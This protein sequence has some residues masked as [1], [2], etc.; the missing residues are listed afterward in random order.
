MKQ[1]SVSPGPRLAALGIDLVI[2]VVGIAYLSSR[3]GVISGWLLNNAVSGSGMTGLIAMAV[4][5]FFGRL[6]G[7]VVLFPLYGLIELFAGGSIGKMIVGLEVRR[8][9]GTSAAF[10]QQLGRYCLKNSSFVIPAAGIVLTVV[11]GLEMFLLAA[12]LLWVVVPVIVGIGYLKIFGSSQ[13]SIHDSWS[14]TAVFATAQR[15]WP[16]T[17]QYSVGCFLLFL[18][19]HA[20]AT[21]MLQ[22]TANLAKHEFTG[23][24]KGSGLATTKSGK[25][26]QF[27]KSIRGAVDPACALKGLPK[28]FE[29]H[30]IKVYS[31]SKR[32]DYQLG[33]SGNET[34]EEMVVVGPTKK[35][36]VLVL[37][38][39]D[40]VMWVVGVTPGAKLAGVIA[41][42]SDQQGIT[43]VGPNIPQAV[44]SGEKKNQCEGMT[45][46]SS[47]KVYEP[48]HTSYIVKLL[49]RGPDHFYGKKRT[50]V[51]EIGT[52]S[53]EPKYSADTRA[54][55]IRDPNLLPT[56]GKGVERLVQQGFLK[57]ADKQDLQRW[58]Q[59]AA[60]TYEAKDLDSL[61]QRLSS[62][63]S[64]NSV[65]KM[66]KQTNL[67]SG[68][69][70]AHSIV[71]IVPAGMT[72]PAE[73]GHSTF[74][75]QS[76]FTC[77]DAWK[78]CHM[79]LK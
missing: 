71:L 57:V 6:F 70:G 31:G 17:I 22:R 52:V 73:R 19:V 29:V 25:S 68:L 49:G 58:K 43:G 32:V 67:P 23:V 26:K 16:R 51:F 72:I 34:G 46:V 4:G 38:G 27:A 77:Q 56:G 63:M 66:V 1:T 61:V 33:E 79:E 15:S 60:R 39:G 36:V 10:P 53:G 42:G 14:R 18:A 7:F 20:A 50:D 75:V 9:D 65:Y 28:D 13:S 11:T 78:H 40:P 55:Y 44:Y 12:T 41:T 64:R 37:N 62:D 45:W 35:P 8:S 24:A 21:V 47:D 74:L 76:D 2:Q 59:G 48:I 54:K 5:F 69:H 3:L 30:F